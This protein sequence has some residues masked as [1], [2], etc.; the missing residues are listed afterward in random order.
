MEAVAVVGLISNIL[1]FVELGYKLISTSKELYNARNE[2]T[3]SNRNLEF[4][5]QEMKRLS[6]SLATGGSLSQM[7]DDE[8]TLLDLVTKCESWADDMLTFLDHLKNKNPGSRIAAFKA[9]MRNYNMRHERHRLKEG[10]DDY[11]VQ[12]DVQLN[13]MTRSST[14]KKLE[15]LS[16]SLELTNQD[17]TDLKRSAKS[18]QGSIL[19]LEMKVGSKFLDQIQDIVQVSEEKALEAKRRLLL[20]ALRHQGM[21]DR[22]YHVEPAHADTFKWL[23]QSKNDMSSKVHDSKK[24]DLEKYPLD[25]RRI[26]PLEHAHNVAKQEIGHRFTSWLR[27]E[28]GIF[29]IS[30]KPG[31]GKS[32]LMKFLY[33]NELTRKYLNEWSNGKE[34]ILAKAFFWRLGN[35]TQTLIS[36]IRSLLHQ[37]LSTAK[38][39]IPIAFPCRW[40]HV[41]FHG[42]SVVHLELAEIEQGLHNLVTDPRTFEHHKLVF[43]IDG[44]DEYQGRHIELVNQLFNWTSSN[45]GNLKICVSSREWNEFMVGFSDCPKLRIH[46]YT[47]MDIMMM[48]HDQ[49]SSRL[50]YPTPISENNIISIATKI[51]FKAEGVF[52]WVCLVLN[53]VKDGILNGDD[54]QELNSKIDSF[55]S[56]LEEL[57]KQ[58]FDSIHVKD[59]Q[60]VFEIFRMV[61]Y[62]ELGL[63]LPLFR[64]WF[65]NKLVDDPDYA[66]KSK[67]QNVSDEEIATILQITRRQIYGRCK[68]FLVVHDYSASPSFFGPPLSNNGAVAFMHSTAYEFLEQSHIKQIIDQTIGH[69]DVFDRI[70]QTFLVCAKVA[71]PE[72]YG[73][74]S[75]RPGDDLFDRELGVYF[76]L[77]IEKE[78]IF[79][80]R[81]RLESRASRF[82]KFLNELKATV[83]AKHGSFRMK[84]Q[85]HSCLYLKPSSW[86]A[87]NITQNA[88]T[89]T[90]ALIDLF[91]ISWSI[92]EFFQH[93]NIARP[94]H[95][96]NWNDISNDILCLLLGTMSRRERKMVVYYEQLCQMLEWCFSKGVISPNHVDFNLPGLRLVDC[97]LITL[98]QRSDYRLWYDEKNIDPSIHL[99]PLRLLELCLRYGAKPQLELWMYDSSNEK[100]KEYIRVCPVLNK[101]G[102]H[103]G[104]MSPKVSPIATFGKQK[105]GLVTVRDLTELWFPHDYKILQELIDKYERDTS[106]EVGTHT[107][108][109]P[110]HLGNQPERDWPKVELGEDLFQWHVTVAG[111]SVVKCSDLDPTDNL[112]NNTY[113]RSAWGSDLRDIR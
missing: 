57:Y 79:S 53:A 22:F 38:D 60:K 37:V 65:L 12:L 31:A 89:S 80:D 50:Q 13:I 39:L 105:H 109:V 14:L 27:N 90:D 66:L 67:T 3:A 95:T 96:P 104:W 44:L 58:L 25:P 29:H 62:M 99:Y 7:T 106:F 42:G 73:F 6:Q 87:A 1:Q 101:R 94:L 63:H 11:R 23:L 59:R 75:D 19:G 69:V 55:P 2:S 5:A 17:M 97:I 32:T 51:E 76:R 84:Y 112:W 48:V 43:L 82:V 45:T 56:E 52:Q 71:R 83:V 47:R 98:I 10:L 78:H 74:N 111:E 70:C 15:S 81:N 54:V 113:L 28:S 107:G 8:Q 110:S 33:N 100:D 108:S 21:E 9:S 26:W 61:N 35:D 34:V 4:M 77:A 40:E 36:L 49:L 64:V 102:I 30:G 18:L 103:E 86:P 93:K 20:D 16:K 46:D 88:W 85:I 91:A 68:G 92:V 24:D 41:D 72:W